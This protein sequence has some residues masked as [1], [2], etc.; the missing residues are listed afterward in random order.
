MHRIRD[1]AINYQAYVLMQVMGNGVTSLDTM[2][3]LFGLG[4][5]MGSSREWTHIRNE[6]GKAEQKKPMRYRQKTYRSRSQP[7]PQGS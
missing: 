2:M 5:H 4:V 1:Y 3:G 7:L 6:L